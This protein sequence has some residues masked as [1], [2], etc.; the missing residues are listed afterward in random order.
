MLQRNPRF[1]FVA[2][3][4][5]PYKVLLKTYNVSTLWFEHSPF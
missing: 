4:T 5:P 1:A 2:L 3:A